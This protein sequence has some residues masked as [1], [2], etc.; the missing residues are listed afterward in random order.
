[1]GAEN[2]QAN[3]RRTGPGIE[4]HRVTKVGGESA[5]EKLNARLERISRN[6]EK[7]KERKRRRVSNS[8]KPPT[9]EEA[10]RDGEAKRFEALRQYEKDSWA[11]WPTIN[12]PQELQKPTGQ[13]CQQ[14]NVSHYWRIMSMVKG[15]TYHLWYGPH[16]YESFESLKEAIEGAK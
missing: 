13:F 10:K 8:K 2:Q 5:D 1:M 16:G 6:S 15:K 3:Y 14:C 11:W 12:N 7:A 9:A 4:S